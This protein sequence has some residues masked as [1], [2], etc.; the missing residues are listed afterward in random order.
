MKIT[1]L[2]LVACALL[3]LSG[4]FGPT[5]TYNTNYH[6][7]S[8]GVELEFFTNCPPEEVYTDTEFEVKVM[9]SNNGAADLNSTEKGIDNSVPVGKGFLMLSYDDYYLKPRAGQEIKHRLLT[10]RGKSLFWPKGEDELISLANLTVKPLQGQ[11]SAPTT[12]VMAT[13]CYPYRTLLTKE[14]C[15]DMNVYSQDVRNQACTNQEL[16]LQDQG[17]PIAVTHI[18]PVFLPEGQTHVRPRFNIHIENVGGGVA[19]S[20]DI[21][22]VKVEDCTPRSQDVLL[23]S[24][25]SV[26]G[27]LGNKDLKLDCLPENITLIQ[28]QADI[29][30]TTDLISIKPNY[31]TPLTIQIDYLYSKSVSK[32]IQIWRS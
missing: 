29:V 16:T 10:M 17:A 20:G 14:I 19:L 11:I 21:E 7:G 1:H 26:K 23:G 9:A 8:E 18:Q 3:L 24:H 25:L 4:C 2:A 30:C 28:N 13:A 27:W 15:V 6:S 5:S 12:Q 31:M 22:N 32:T